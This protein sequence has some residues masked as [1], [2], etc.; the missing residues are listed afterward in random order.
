MN[1][2]NKWWQ[3]GLQFLKTARGL[4]RKQGYNPL[5]KLTA[6]LEPPESHLRGCLVSSIAVETSPPSAY[7]CGT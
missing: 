6:P 3:V 2:N 7:T 5:V 1:N 4:T